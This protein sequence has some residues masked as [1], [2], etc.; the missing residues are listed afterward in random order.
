MFHK[1]G[2]LT[3]MSIVQ[4][5]SGIHGLSPSVYNYLIG[6]PVSDIIVSVTKVSDSGA[7]E[8]LEKGSNVYL[9]ITM[10]T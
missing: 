8:V 10:V 5:G 2:Q 9:L 6:V 4:G 3:S 1:I 7:K